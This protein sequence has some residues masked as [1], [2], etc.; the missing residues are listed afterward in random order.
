MHI[1]DSLFPVQKKGSTGSLTA[2][3]PYRDL[4]SPS[5][6]NSNIVQYGM[7]T[8]LIHLWGNK[9]SPQEIYAKVRHF[10]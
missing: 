7:W 6:A 3:E 9:L 4:R 1:S 10:L 8:K 2:P 5:N